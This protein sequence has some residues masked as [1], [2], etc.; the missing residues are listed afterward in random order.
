MLRVDYEK[1]EIKGTET[2]ILAEFTMLARN[3]RKLL[4]KDQSTE[5]ADAKIAK[6]IELSKKT[7]D[8]LDEEVLKSINE[9]GEMLARVCS[10]EK[11]K[12]ENDD[13]EPS[14]GN[15][16]F[17]NFLKDLFCGGAK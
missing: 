9:L 17:D 4:A 12:K 5:Y 11:S 3:L 7:S 6:T 15:S 1:I 13:K 16:D 2:H 8:E 10:E 14:T